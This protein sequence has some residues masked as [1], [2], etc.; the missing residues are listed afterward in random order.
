MGGGGRTEST[1]QTTNT[2]TS[3]SSAISGDNL[4]TVLSGV[5]N[6]SVN[7]NSTDHGAVKSAGEIA[8]AALL[9]NQFAMKEASNLGA[10]AIDENGKSLG[11]ALDFGKDALNFGEDALKESS[12][13]MREAMAEN[14]AVS[15]G[16]MDSVSKNAI[17]AL[18]ENSDVNKR[19]MDNMSKNTI[20]SLKENSNVNKRAMDNMQKNSANTTAAVKAMAAQS[21]ENARAALAMAENTASRSQ[22]G[23][24]GEMSKVAIA[25]A[26]ALSLGVAIVAIKGAN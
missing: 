1:N 9:S 20:Y 15:R 6:S 11:K 18:K 10:K 23:A 8:K 19:A 12:K 2:N 16:A 25:V 5:N 24:A 3:G 14:G 17:Y 26:I 7:I 4:G 22:I 13:T 21:G